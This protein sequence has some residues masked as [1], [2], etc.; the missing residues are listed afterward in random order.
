MD[1]RRRTV[2]KKVAFWDDNKQGLSGNNELQ[3]IDLQT[4]SA[5]VKVYYTNKT[6]TRYYTNG[7]KFVDNVRVN[8]NGVSTT[9]NN[10]TRITA[11]PLTIKILRKRLGNTPY[12]EFEI[13]WN[14]INNVVSLKGAITVILK[15]ISANNGS[16]WNGGSGRFWDG[17]G[18]AGSPYG[19]TRSSFETG[20]GVQNTSDSIVVSSDESNFISILGDNFIQNSSVLEDIPDQGEN[21]E[22]D[23]SPVTEWDESFSLAQETLDAE[24]GL[25]AVVEGVA[26]TEYSV[27][28]GGIGAPSNDLCYKSLQ[29]SVYSGTVPG[30][31]GTLIING[32][33]YVQNTDWVSSTAGAAG[34]LINGTLQSAGLG[35]SAS[36]FTGFVAGRIALV[37]RGAATFQ[38]KVNN[39]IA[40]GAVGVII[41]NNVAGLITPSL[42]ASIPVVMVTQA[43]GSSLVNNAASVS[44]N[45]GGAPVQVVVTG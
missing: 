22:G 38:T 27:G 30:C 2:T 5:R 19:L 16:V 11:G 36:D 41:Y 17:F 1:N 45:G 25:D 15:R 44:M 3:L 18:R 8:L 21:G 31:D 43:T 32:T 20:I 14:T 7:A 33:S 9:Y 13:S 10:T 24:G 28:W 40:A 26:G 39:A 4:S 23:N 37:Q 6:W 42:T 29:S 34:T 12:L 35:N